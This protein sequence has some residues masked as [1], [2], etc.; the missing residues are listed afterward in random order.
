MLSYNYLLVGRKAPEFCG[1]AVYD[2]DFKEIK[3]VDY[4]GKYL[5]LCLK[6]IIIDDLFIY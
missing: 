3:L 2:Q 4:K 6:K 1:T 5:I